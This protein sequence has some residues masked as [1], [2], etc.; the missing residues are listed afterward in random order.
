MGPGATWEENL[1]PSMVSI[2]AQENLGKPNLPPTS[3]ATFQGQ[4]RKKTSGPLTQVRWVK[5]NLR[6]SPSSLGHKRK[7]QTYLLLGPTWEEKLWPPTWYPSTQVPWV[8]ENLWHAPSELGRKR[9][10]KPTSY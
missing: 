1:C 4:R 6:H 8:K 10:H 9:K 2:I 3:G 5:E 7:H